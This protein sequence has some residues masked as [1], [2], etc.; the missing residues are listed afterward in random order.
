MNLNFNLTSNHHATS[1]YVTPHHAKPRHTAPRNATSRHT[2]KPLTLVLQVSD[3]GTLTIIDVQKSWD[4]GSY[5]C[6]ANADG[7]TASSNVKV[8]VKGKLHKRHKP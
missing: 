3:D 2:S 4:A 7:L 5:T 6:V 1:H 8:E